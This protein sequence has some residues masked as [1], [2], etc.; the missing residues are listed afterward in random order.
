MENVLPHLDHLEPHALAVVVFAICLISER[1]K[2][3]YM[4]NIPQNIKDKML[5]I[6][7]YLKNIK[8]GPFVFDTKSNNMV[9]SLPKIDTEAC[10]FY[11]SA[12]KLS[13][14]YCN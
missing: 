3:A 1:L 11:T 2:F 7:E 12:S 10:T 5:P 13:I 6:N 4:E 9:V 14:Y 8:C